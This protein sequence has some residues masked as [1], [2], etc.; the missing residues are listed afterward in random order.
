[1]IWEPKS[2]KVFRMKKHHLDEV[3][4]LEERS[5]SV[6]W[7]RK[8]FL[9]ELK[10]PN[11]YYFIAVLDKKIAGYAGM[12]HVVNE[13]HIT[14]VAVAEEHRQKGIGTMLVKE[15]VAVSEKKHMIGLTLEVRINNKSAHALYA[16]TGFKPE[17]IRKNYYSDTKE[18]AVIMWYYSENQEYKI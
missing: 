16:K 17:G 10:N 7:S 15:L 11:A 13:G 5:F 1:M 9:E 2:I 6:P 8:S 14:K 4:E 3:M 18:D 12:W